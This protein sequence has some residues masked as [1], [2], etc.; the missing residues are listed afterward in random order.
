MGDSFS[1]E[2]SVQ[3][4][5]ATVSLNGV[6]ASVGA[7]VRLGDGEVFGSEMTKAV[8]PHLFTVSVLC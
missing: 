8:S 1:G 5:S 3:E 2:E 6:G 7:G 4:T